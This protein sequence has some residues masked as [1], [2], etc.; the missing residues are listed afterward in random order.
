MSIVN[1]NRVV[2]TGQLTADPELE[3]LPSGFLV[4][5]FQVQVHRRRQ[6]PDTGAWGERIVHL[7]VVAFGNLAESTARYLYAGR[8]VAVDGWLDVRTR[9]GVAH[10]VRIVADNVQFIGAPPDDVRVRS[11]RTDAPAPVL[12][13]AS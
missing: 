12:A 2:L 8:Q 10:E 4:C 3:A 7:D 5:A 13:L 6:D 11:N 1:L 9:D